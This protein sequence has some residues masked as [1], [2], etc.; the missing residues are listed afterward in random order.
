[1]PSIIESLLKSLS[2]NVKIDKMGGGGNSDSRS[3][4]LNNNSLDKK[5]AEKRRR[6]RACRIEELEGREMLSATP[7]GDGGNDC[8]EPEYGPFVEISSTSGGIDTQPAPGGS[9]IV[10]DGRTYNQHEYNLVQSQGLQEYATWRQIDGEHRLTE[11]NAHAEGISGAFDFS[12]CSELT[13]LRL[14]SNPGIT[15]ITL[16]GC[17]N[18]TYLGLETSPVTELDLADSPKLE[19]LNINMTLITEL[20]WSQLTTNLHTF[21]NSGTYI[22]DLSGLTGLTGL[23]TL[24]LTR[25]PDGPQHT[26]FDLSALVNLQVIQILYFP[27]KELDLT[28]LTKLIS[29]GLWNNELTTLRGLDTIEGVLNNIRL[30]GNRFFLSTLDEIYRTVEPILYPV[31]WN[32]S[33]GWVDVHRR[34]SPNQTPEL[35]EFITSNNRTVD[36][37]SEFEFEALSD[38]LWFYPDG[39]QVDPSLVTRYPN[40]TF[41]FDDSL[42]QSLAAQGLTLANLTSEEVFTTYETVFTW[43]AAGNLTT[44]VSADLITH[45]GNGIFEF[46]KTLDVGS[47]FVVKMENEA[48]PRAT[49]MVSTAITVGVFPTATPP[50]PTAHL[51]SSK[52]T[53]SW[54]AVPGAVGYELWVYEGDSDV[55]TSVLKMTNRS[56]EFDVPTDGSNLR[57][58]LVTISESGD[59]SEPSEVYSLYNEREHAFVM[60]HG[61][62]KPGPHYSQPAVW[63]II[64][65]QFRLTEVVIRD[66][67]A[68]QFYPIQTLDFSNFTE[69][70]S[71]LLDRLEVSEIDLRGCEKLEN[72][73]IYSLQLLSALHI[74]D[75]ENLKELDLSGVGQSGTGFQLDLSGLINLEKLTLSNVRNNVTD[76]DLTGLSKLQH[77]VLSHS[78]TG[79]MS[80]SSLETFTGLNGTNLPELR[81]IRISFTDT[82]ESQMKE[83]ELTGFSN[84]TSGAQPALYLS[85]PSLESLKITDTPLTEMNRI[86][87][88][89]SGAYG[90]WAYLDLP[91]LTLLDVAGNELTKLDISSLTELNVLDVS[92]NQLTALQGDYPDSLRVLDVS[93]NKLTALNL[94]FPAGLTQLDVSNNLIPL[95][96]LVEIWQSLPVGAEMFINDDLALTPYS[97]SDRTIDLS[98]FY[99]FGTYLST[100]TFTW[101]RANG[102]PATE[103]ITVL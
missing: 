82:I 102:E 68:G 67:N 80:R 85:M 99:S 1:M 88:S 53:L 76:L 13:R 4:S 73:Q 84:L 75:L 65:G 101:Y 10:V 19:W 8:E 48:Y 66:T 34:F 78:F 25:I 103:G 97:R 24:T 30:E 50:K 63:S 71:V 86:S 95:A 38:V 52:L 3:N 98:T 6:G 100:T 47:S 7:F 23:H 92:N 37:S 94:T 91:N 32:P 72:L 43:Y 11:I 21:H 41:D 89:I 2:E 64:D 45:L 27:I 12:G 90:N 93:N 51:T 59:Y 57:I 33:S 83:L 35:P 54:D 5:R 18:L 40:G 69:L 29:I 87:F 16:T 9:T 20:D 26:S 44:P 62:D 96:E 58:V 61:L 77:L 70:R 31:W 39:T 49:N 36:L 79:L 17:V 46:N 55:V 81:S 28:G 74:K 14:D 60:E 56:Y 22:S 42:V 15:A